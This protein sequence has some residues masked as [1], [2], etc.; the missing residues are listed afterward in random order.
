VMLKTMLRTSLTSSLCTEIM[1]LRKAAGTSSRTQ[2]S[3]VTSSDPSQAGSQALKKKRKRA[4]HIPIDLSS[5]LGPI[6]MSDSGTPSGKAFG[7]QSSF[8]PCAVVASSLRLPLVRS[9]RS[10]SFLGAG[11][12]NDLPSVQL[13]LQAM[14]SLDRLAGLRHL[15]ENISDDMVRGI[16]HRTFDILGRLI[17]AVADVLTSASAASSTSN[18]NGSSIQLSITSAVSHARALDVLLLAVPHALATLLPLHVEAP[19]KR[20]KTWGSHTQDNRTIMPTSPEAL[21]MLIGDLV[22]V[23]LVESLA[24]LPPAS[25]LIPPS[26]TSSTSKR[27][28]IPSTC[29]DPRN[30][31]LGLFERTLSALVS[32]AKTRVG[33]ATTLPMLKDRLCSVITRQLNTSFSTSPADNSASSDHPAGTPSPNTGVIAHLCYALRTVLDAE[34]VSGTRSDT[35]PLGQAMQ[36]T[37]LRELGA[38]GRRLALSHADAALKRD[39]EGDGFDSCGSAGTAEERAM[40]F[41]VVEFAFLGQPI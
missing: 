21:L 8:L 18:I 13:V 14:T 39:F 23:P 35:D 9:D 10:L 26:S 22:L 28:S 41:A 24:L 1:S 19:R 15:D 4:A 25:E 36:T 33:Y 2:T 7:L 3:E 32:H 40:F 34:V 6:S 12:H 16:S 11:I 27:K 29:L 17:R 20:Q 30:T 5:V 38:L 37:I 31:L